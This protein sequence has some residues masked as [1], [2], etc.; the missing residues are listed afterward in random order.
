M[1]GG[2]SGAVGRWCR[3]YGIEGEGG[4]VDDGNDEI[5]DAVMREGK[6]STEWRRVMCHEVDDG[7]CESARSA[8]LGNASPTVN[9]GARS[10]EL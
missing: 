9:R 5:L 3:R 2:V 1:D 6:E 10:E 8:E 4:L 7:P